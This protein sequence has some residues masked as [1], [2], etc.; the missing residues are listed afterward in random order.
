MRC[1]QRWELPGHL[2]PKGHNSR[3]FI[4]YAP[5]MTFLGALRCIL[6]AHSHFI[7]VL[8]LIPLYSYLSNVYSEGLVLKS[9]RNLDA[10]NGYKSCSLTIPM[11]Q[12][13]GMACITVVVD[14]FTSQ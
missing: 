6:E 4:W 3:G 2:G 7:V 1:R 12:H 11:N 5:L 9:F 13:W 10:S 8:H 14:Y